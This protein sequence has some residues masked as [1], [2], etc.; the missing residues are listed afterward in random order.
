MNQTDFVRIK[1]KLQQGLLTLDQANVALV[2][3]MG[4]REVSGKLPRNL[5]NA[6]LAAVKIGELGHLPKRGS[7]PEMFFHPNSR[8][9]AIEMQYEHLAKARRNVLTVCI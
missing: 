6:F 3:E 2:R 8:D 5:R 1:D 4:V 9:R 7:A